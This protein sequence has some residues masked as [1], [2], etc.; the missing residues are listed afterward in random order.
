VLRI[1]EHHLRSRQVSRVVYGAIIGLALVVALQDHPPAPWVMIATLLGTAVAVGLAELYSELLGTETR[2]RRRV[3]P[4]EVRAE[5]VGVAAV[6]FGIAFPA[7]FFVLAAAG[8]LETGTAFV[9]ARWS[10]LA[11]IGLYG[12]AAARLAGAGLPSALLHG[13]AVG[14]IGGFLITLKALVH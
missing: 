3:G 5:L 6:T 7:V 10:G 8:A 13:L 14:V 12:F 1:L 9:I 2:M 4:A 11:L